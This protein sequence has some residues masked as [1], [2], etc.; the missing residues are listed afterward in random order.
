MKFLIIF[1]LLTSIVYAEPMSFRGIPSNTLLNESQSKELKKQL[2]GKIFS[3]LMP[4]KNDYVNEVDRGTVKF[5]PKKSVNMFGDEVFEASNYS[6]HKLTIPDGTTVQGINFTQK[7]PHTPAI[8][9]KNITFIECNLANVEIDPT[10]TLIDTFNIHFKRTLKNIINLE[11]GNLKF[12][13]SHQVEKDGKF[14][15]EREYEEIVDPDNYD[16]VMLHLNT[17]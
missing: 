3:E 9:G 2:K 15:E 12:I 17:E 14:V 7:K 4:A 16:R 1:L 13:I 8:Q 10:W 11:D 5:N 6:Y